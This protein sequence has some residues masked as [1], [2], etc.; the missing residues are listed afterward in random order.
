MVALRGSFDAGAAYGRG[1]RFHEL[2]PFKIHKAGWKWQF[3]EEK[4]EHAHLCRDAWP[5]GFSDADGSFG[6]RQPTAGREV[7]PSAP[8]HQS[9][10][11]WEA[12]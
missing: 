5:A 6:L 9:L 12:P 4:S 1:V 8:A 11:H 2:P 10:H 3:L 7:W